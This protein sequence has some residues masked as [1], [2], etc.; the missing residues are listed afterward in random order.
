M[1]E[2]GTSW[3]LAVELGAAGALVLMNNASDSTFEAAAALASVRPV[4]PWAHSWG[5]ERGCGERTAEV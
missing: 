4:L 1:T 5:G 3:A 2:A